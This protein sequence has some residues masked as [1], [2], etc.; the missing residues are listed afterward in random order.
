MNWADSQLHL[1]SVR[2]LELPISFH[3][4][5]LWNLPVWLPLVGSGNP[6]FG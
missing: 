1:R 5:E 2:E 6:P 3:L 4:T